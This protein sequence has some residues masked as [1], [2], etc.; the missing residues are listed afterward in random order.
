MEDHRQ[1]RHS[2]LP[3]GG[4]SRKLQGAVELGKI[5]GIQVDRKV[6]QRIP[7]VDPKHAGR[8]QR[9]SRCLEVEL[10]D[11]HNLRPAIVVGQHAARDR[12]IRGVRATL[13]EGRECQVRTYLDRIGDV[14]GRPTPLRGHRSTYL[15]VQ[16][17]IPHFAGAGNLQDGPQ[18][19]A[20]HAD[21]RKGV[22]ALYRGHVDRLHRRGRSDISGGIVGR[23]G[24]SNRGRGG[25]RRTRRHFA[26]P[27]LDL[28][29]PCDGAS[30]GKASG[31][32]VEQQLGRRDSQL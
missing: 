3:V 13:P 14:G 19:N 22:G 10:L 26:Q 5:P 7:V 12:H 18:G 1:G 17:Q 15:C 25:R 32:G 29:I 20:L 23:L 2:L 6:R 21:L 11:P 31:Q 8:R 27:V 28:Q 16:A 30:P 9:G 4:H 24:G